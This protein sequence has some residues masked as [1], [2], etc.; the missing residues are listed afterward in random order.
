MIFRAKK[1]AGS[2]VWMGVLLVLPAL[3]WAQRIDDTG[4][5]QFM[6]LLVT[7]SPDLEE[8][9]HPKDISESKRLGITYQEAPAKFSIAR[10]LGTQARARLKQSPNAY[11]FQISDADDGWQIVDVEISGTDR[12]T[13]FY[14]QE[15]KWA[16][17]VR[18][19]TRDWVEEETFFFRFLISDTTH[20]N[21]YARKL[22]DDF[23]YLNLKKL[24]ASEDAINTLMY[25]KIIYAHCSD[26]D[27]VEK[28]T[29]YWARGMYQLSSDYVISSYNSHAHEIA[30]LLMN[31]LL[32]EAPL[33]PNPVF[34]EGFAT[35]LG[36]RGGRAPGV[37]FDMAKFLDQSGMVTYE[38]LREPGSFKQ[39]D[40][41]VSYPLAG[42]LNAH[43]MEVSS[44]SLYQ[45]AYLNQEKG[46]A[47]LNLVDEKAW[48]TYLANKVPPTMQLEPDFN[49]FP[50]PTGLS[51]DVIDGRFYIRTEKSLTMSVGQPFPGYRSRLWED[52]FPG[53]D[54]NGEIYGLKID[55]SEIT[56]Y[57]FFRDT[58][59]AKYAAGFQKEPGPLRKDGQ[60]YQISVD[61]KLINPPLDL[62]KVTEVD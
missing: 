26:E 32:A 48:D 14:F 6:A 60:L 34:L 21:P 56:L 28:L 52:V 12:K 58:I 13:S 38:Q 23:V 62:L 25:H 53:R 50:N 55:E 7:E 30:H 9:V 57:D 44:F 24:G 22:L 45:Q 27:Q 49:R 18:Y 59:I 17:Q 35:A 36:G 37:L 2:F 61:A 10:G 1:I 11:R 46:M 39:I 41:S 20:S 54:Y 51:F 47:L 5:R 19:H 29:G 43:L 15:G 8:W 31:Y 40:P 4:F 16:N 33:Y 42:L 3:A